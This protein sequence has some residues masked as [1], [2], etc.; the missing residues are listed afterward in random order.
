ME[1]SNVFEKLLLSGVQ[2][3]QTCF[4]DVETDF[5]RNFQPLIFNVSTKIMHTSGG[6]SSEEAN[7]A[8]WEAGRGAVA[9]AAKV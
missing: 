3:E 9:G 8:A 4:D 6:L 2:T 7:G 5:S 1:E